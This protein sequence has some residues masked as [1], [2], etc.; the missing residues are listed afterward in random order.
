MKAEPA[1]RQAARLETW[2]QFLDQRPSDLWRDLVLDGDVRAP[3]LRVLGSEN[4]SK[5]L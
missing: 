1:D 3:A 4:T 2:F 5:C